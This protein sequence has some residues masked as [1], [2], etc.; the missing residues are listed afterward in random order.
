VIREFDAQRD[1]A[2]IRRAFVELQDF[3]REIDPR[4]P[5]GEAIAD[6]Y[7]K[8]MFGRGAELAGVILVAEVDDDIAGFV[9]VWTRYRSS[10]PDD[11]PSE[12]GFI[13]DLV[14]LASHRGRGIGRALLMAAEVRAREAGAQEIR[15]SVKAGNA[16]ARALY[17]TE[18]YEPTDIYLEKEL[19][20]AEDVPPLPE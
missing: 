7:L 17:E 18:G 2:A 8:L 15:L 4:M 12:H 13:S 1:G 5:T 11:D 9:S 20:E 6:A 10:E 3:E 14:V 16:T 19:T